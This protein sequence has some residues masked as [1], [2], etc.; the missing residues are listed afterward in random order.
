MQNR[1]EALYDELLALSYEC[2]LDSSAWHRLL[3][4]LSEA[5][6][7][8]RGILMLW[9]EQ[10]P[11]AQ[12]SSFYACEADSVEAYNRYFCTLDPTGP[13]L[14]HRDKGLWYHDFA[15][16]TVQQI[17]RSPYYQEFKRPYGMRGVSCVKLQKSQQQSAFL[18]LLTNLDARQPSAQQ[19]ALLTRISPHL[20]RTA[21]L[22]NVVNGLELELEAR[23]LLQAQHVTP[24]WLVNAEGRV[25]FCNDA[26]ERR[27]K[28]PGL[29]L[30][31]RNDRLT[32]VRTSGV[33]T[34]MLR[35]AC[36]S[37]GA[38]RAGWCRLP[39]AS[40]GE[41]LITPVNAEAWFNLY[42]QEPLA[43]VALLD[44]QPRTQLLAELFQ[45]TPAECRLAELIVQGLSPE[46]CAGRIGVSINTVR[47]QLRALFRKTGTDRQAEL[48]SL[49]MRLG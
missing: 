6:G 8:Q 28:E 9:D 2:V 27:L 24:L 15:E 3:A 22:A 40:G 26:A 29:P 47:T 31:Q 18:S 13:L 33:F 38:P 12:V 1:H 10:R 14:E 20:V 30:V 44:N 11:H 21:Q 49:F 36:G 25:V 34:A 37:K 32:L 41:L 19:Q 17:N 7:R 35:A 16:L 43:L 45:L 48:V 23:Q 4:R 42:F 46:E 5:S 39:E